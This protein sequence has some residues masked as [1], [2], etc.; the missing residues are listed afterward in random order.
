MC[1]IMLGLLP[2]VKLLNK[3]QHVSAFSLDYAD[4]D[5]Q[6]LLAKQLHSFEKPSA[7]FPRPFYLVI[8]DFSC[9]Y[10][11]RQVERS[12]FGAPQALLMC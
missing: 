4:S 10:L 5:L 6:L 1:C 2:A 9:F 8:S 12:W 7:F 3:S 11:S